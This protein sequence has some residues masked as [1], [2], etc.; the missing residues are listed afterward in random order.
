[1]VPLE[2]PRFWIELGRAASPVETIASARIDLYSHYGFFLPFPV[3]SGVDSKVDDSGL[4]S[5][6][7][8][9]GFLASR[10]DL[11]CPFAITSSSNL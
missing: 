3:R 9:F 7:T 10:L 4:F 8:C 11:F 5:D 2:F 1:V 6:F